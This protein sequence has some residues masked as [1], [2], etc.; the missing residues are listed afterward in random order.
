MS[1]QPETT[2][3]PGDLP[4]TSQAA[5][6]PVPSRKSKSALAVKSDFRNP[7]YYI[8]RELSWIDFNERVLEEAED[9]TNPLLERLKFLVIFGTNLDEFF[10]IRVSGLMEQLSGGVVELAPDGFTPQEQ[11]RAINERLRPLMERHGRHLVEQIMPKLARKGIVIHPFRS[12]SEAE[13]ARLHNYFW[14]E[15]LPVLTPL[16]IDPGHPFPHV[17]NR[18]LNLAFVVRDPRKHVHEQEFHFAVV[19]VPTVLGRFIK[20]Y[21]E[22]SG[23]HFVLLEEVIAAYASAL[24]PGLDV[25]SSYTFRVLRD[26]DIEVTEDEAEDLLTM[27]EEQVRRR[28]WG[29]AVRLDVSSNM[30]QYVRDILMES[31]ELEPTDVYE[32]PGPRN[33]TD[34][35]AL[36]R[37]DYRD[38]KDKPFNSYMLESFR[39]EERSV[40][41]VIR[42]KDILLHHP[43]DSF[44]NVA[45]FIKAAAR[46]PKVL[47]IKQTLYRAGGDSP[48]VQSLIEAA[49][50]GKQVTALV[51]LKARFDEENNIVWAKR[52]EQAGVHVV[53][54]LIGLKTHCK[55][56]MIVRRDDT[57]LPRIYMHL[58]TG[59]Y[60]TVTSRLYTDVGLITANPDF[61]ADA[62]NL[63]NYL[64][65]YGS[66]IEWR[67]LIM[68]PLTLRQRLL[69]LIHREAERHTPEQPGHIIAKLNAIVDEEVIRAL[70]SASQQGVKIDLLVRGICCLRPGLEGVSDNIRVVSVVGRFLEHSRILY[71]RNGGEEEFYLSSAD[72]MPRNLNRRVELMFP[73][74]DS[75]NR[76][77][78]KEIFEIYLNDNVKARELGSDG[79][80]RRK[81]KQ[82]GETNAQEYFIT[83]I[84]QSDPA[85]EG[86]PRPKRSNKQHGNLVGK[87]N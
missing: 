56:A 81:E 7:Q 62:I 35:M 55:I 6:Q 11:L 37:L 41:S 75:D 57:G 66:S 16:A 26:A 48:I 76:T 84:R 13:Q 1:E 80:Y 52:L 25:K 53:Y 34:F 59:N 20:V 19:Q 83:Q 22:K 18:T 38:L 72:W 32:T 21:A 28:K 44:T 33:L 23:D 49:E 61:G 45:D 73:V 30:P 40:F 31:L 9:P 15:A 85:T 4:P 46:D 39:D 29:E 42:S 50:N 67:K 60:N 69:E 51:E 74:E 24:F 68:A 77:R 65:G 14:Q 58:G 8:N 47:A 87:K 3:Q 78:L 2:T 82:G 86:A 54:G 43:Y 71:F 64:T 36:Y 17:L 63:F 70:Y 27:M 10:M 5:N 79:V 12:L